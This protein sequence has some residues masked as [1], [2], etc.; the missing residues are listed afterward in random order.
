MQ[1]YTPHII[2]KPE[3]SAASLER[4]DRARILIMGGLCTLLLI[5][6]YFSL[7]P[8]P[9]KGVSEFILAQRTL[10]YIQ[11]APTVPPQVADFLDKTLEADYTK[12]IQPLV[13]QLTLLSL[14]QDQS[15]ESILVLD[16][17]Q[18]QE[19]LAKLNESSDHQ[20]TDL[21]IK[22]ATYT[23]YIGKNN[24]ITQNGS[25]IIITPS[26]QALQRILEGIHAPVGGTLNNDPDFAR[27][28]HE[29]PEPYFI[30]GRPGDISDYITQLSSLYLPTPLL[31]DLSYRAVG[32]GAR[33]E[34]NVLLGKMIGLLPT[35]LQRA[36]EKAYR[37][38]LLP[39][40]PLDTELLIGGQQLN[41]QLEKSAPHGNE[42]NRIIENTISTYL[43][44]SDAEKEIYPLMDD[45]FAFSKNAETWAFLLQLNTRHENELVNV[46][47]DRF[48]TGAQLLRTTQ[49]P[50]TIVDGT[51][52][53]ELFPA[54]TKLTDTT[55]TFQDIIIHQL[56]L[57]KDGQLF[58]AVAQDK[59]LLSNDLE[60]IKKIIVLT[61]ELGHSTRESELYTKMLQPIL[62][63][64]ELFGAGY[65]NLSQNA[66]Y[67]LHGLKS[68]FGFSKRTFTDYIE[69]QFSLAL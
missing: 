32:I 20:K 68:T 38:I 50:V 14:Q 59:L 11:M 31:Q 64:P 36:E 21:A 25:Y 60:Q 1:E 42:L 18:P 56:D 6:G 22:N 61:Q 46:L 2:E 12:T 58:Q 30:F 63:N 19:V 5:V 8:Q 29:L 13:T 23:A 24:V 43:P 69:T 41:T 49:K 45:E 16:S 44:G 17:E 53:E 52:G 48:L 54:E 35:S 67:I 66:P 7:A 10:L 4:L 27:L 15:A 3:A 39:Y 51:E 28:V 65:M 26:I 62:K 40:I 33:Y 47:W 55:I 37:A 34:N 9:I 57:G